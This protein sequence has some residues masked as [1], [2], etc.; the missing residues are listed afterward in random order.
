MN[1]RIAQLSDLHIGFDR[2]NPREHNLLR[3]EAVV[4]RLGQPGLR[5]DLLLLSG[6]LTE[7]GDAASY[8]RLRDAIAN[9]A[10]PI[11]VIPGNHDD[12]GNLVEAFPATQ[13]AD[14]FVQYVIELGSMRIIMLD[15]LEPDRHGGAF[16]EVR[17]CWLGARLAEA[18]MVPTLIVMHHPPLQSGIAWM[19]DA[20][21]ATWIMR[22]AATVAGHDQIIGIASGHV[23]RSVIARWQG[24]PSL[25]CPSTAPAVGLHLDPIS[26]AKRDDRPM[27]VNV[28]SR[29]SHSQLEWRKPG[30]SFWHCRRSHGACPPRWCHEPAAR[31]ACRGTP[32]TQPS[33]TATPSI[34]RS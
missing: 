23:H 4:A 12:R 8:A 13:L 20:P 30:Q 26:P 7:H 22:F 34:P 5:P 33:G 16:C 15:T 6:D 1:L 29:L 24:I 17:S 27:I 14:G 19:D 21:D 31:Y 9:V 18:P 2:D 28:S 25:I 10:C 11:H 32:L 3:L